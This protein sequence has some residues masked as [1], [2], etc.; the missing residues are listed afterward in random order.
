M[1][2]LDVEIVLG[3][4]ESLHPELAGE[5]AD[6]AGKVFGARLERPG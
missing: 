3:P 2:I 1:P 4:G 5:L 6:R